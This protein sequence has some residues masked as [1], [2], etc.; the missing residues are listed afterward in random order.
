MSGFI[1]KG[2]STD[3]ILPS[4]KLFLVTF[5]QFESLTGS[6]RE[7]IVGN[8][9]LLR[10]FP[11]EYGTKSSNLIFD[12]A[13]VKVNNEPFTDEEQIEVERWLSSPKFSSELKII[14]N[15]GIV[16]TLYYGKFTRTEWHSC[17]GGWAG[18][19]FT[20]ENKGA[21]PY[22][23]FEHTFNI[24]GSETISFNCESDELEEF[25]YPVISITAT[26]ATEQV[27]IINMTDNNNSVSLRALDRLEIIM[28]CNL[29]MLQDATTS[30]VISF[31][32]IGWTDVGNIYW[33]RLI[34]GENTL[35]VIGTVN[36]TITYDA[37]YKKVGGWL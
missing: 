33:L 23:H 16:T 30:G 2:K 29:C 27:S 8:T 19:T 37:P 10:P 3:T 26:E 1:Y 25:I 36:I 17:L 34:P 18:V 24:N 28:D 31:S 4:S 13:L 7:N 15:D 9:T 20:F 32:D 11:N 5:S 12:Y 6:N 21:Y 14:N 22:K 35:E